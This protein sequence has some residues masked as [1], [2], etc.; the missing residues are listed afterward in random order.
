M[1]PKGN[2]HKISPGNGFFDLKEVMKI[3]EEWGSGGI[4]K[5]LLRYTRMY[6]SIID[7]STRWP[8][9]GVAVIFIS[10]TCKGIKL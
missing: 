8:T 2:K 9:N 5:T 7:W 4:V 6:K 10:N 1:S 3:Q